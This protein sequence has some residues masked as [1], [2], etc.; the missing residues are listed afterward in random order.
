MN[1]MKHDAMNDKIKE[2]CKTCEKNTSKRISM[3]REVSSSYRADLDGSNSYREA[4]KE[5][6]TF[7]MDREAVEK[8]SRLR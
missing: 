7:S 3:D 1:V 4:I 5:T 8:L 2:R 6:E